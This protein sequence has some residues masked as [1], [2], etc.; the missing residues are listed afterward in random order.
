FL[1]TPGHTPE[2]IAVLVEQAGQPARLFTGDLLFV[3]AVGRPDLLGADVTRRLAS[4]LFGSLNRVMAMDDD[5]EVHPG[6]GAG[7]LCGA[8]IVDL[9]P[10][11][12]FAAGHPYGAISVG[13]GPKVGYWGGWVIPP[14]SHVVLLADEPAHAHDA[15]MQLLRVGLDRVDGSVAGG[16]DA[17]VGAG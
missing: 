8:G 2:H 12:A 6:H 7:S 16:Y 5:V 17:W 13:F 15:A 10:A 11:E 1:H 3:G 9:R 14:D 4:E